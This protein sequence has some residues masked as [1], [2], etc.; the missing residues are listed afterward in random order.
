MQGSYNELNELLQS[1]TNRDE[2]S[3]ADGVLTVNMPKVAEFKPRRIPIRVG[4]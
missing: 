3:M 4:E 2:A 1:N